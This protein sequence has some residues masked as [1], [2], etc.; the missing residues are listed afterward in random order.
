MAT[1]NY[2]VRDC[3]VCG[4]TISIPGGRDIPADIGYIKTKRRTVVL[5]HK[6]CMK[7]RK[8]NGHNQGKESN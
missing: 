2:I 7:E 3:P 8:Q 1:S 5:V 6:N 4:K